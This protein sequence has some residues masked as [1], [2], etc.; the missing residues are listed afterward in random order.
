LIP[1]IQKVTDKYKNIASSIKAK[2]LFP[3]SVSI[4]WGG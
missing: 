1:Y 2:F 3:F 4:N